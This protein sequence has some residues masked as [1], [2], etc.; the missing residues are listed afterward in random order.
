MLVLH[1]RDAAADFLALHGLD[2]G[3]HLVLAEIAARQL[4]HRLRGQVEGRQRDEVVE[5]ARAGRDVGLEAGQTRVRLKPDLG[6][7]VVGLHQLV[8]FRVV[9]GLDLALGDPLV[10]HLLA[11]VQGPVE[12][13]RVVVGQLGVRHFLADLGHHAGDLIHVRGVGLDPQQVRA[14]IAQAGNAVLDHAGAAGAFLEREQAVRQ[15]DR[16]HE[17][18][19]LEDRELA[20]L[21]R[22]GFGDLLGL[23]PLDVLAGQ[24]AR[25]LADRHLLGQAGAKAVGSCDDHALVDAQLLEGEAAGAQL[26]DEVLARDGD[27]AVLVAALLGVRHLVLDLQAAGAGLDEF[28]GQQVGRVFVAEARVD[29]GDDRDDMGFKVVDLIDDL[30]AL[31]VRARGFQRAEQVVHG[32]LVGLAQRGVDFLDQVGDGGL[33]MHRLV[34]QVAPAIAK[35]RDHPARQVDI[36]ALG[37]A[38]HPLDGLDHLLGVKARPAAER[39]GELRRVGVIGRHVGAHHHRHLAGDVQ[40]GVPGVLQPQLH[41]VVD[42]HPAGGLAGGVAGRDLGV[43]VA[44]GLAGHR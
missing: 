33:F 39:L 26:F 24:I 6:R 43:Q 13:G 25:A 4:V 27:L 20:F 19:A 28:L 11:K 44:E 2:V 16:F 40:V 17:L 42:R 38:A 8:A 23:E 35:P 1:R 34:G 10:A 12:A 41:D 21:D 5:H 36:G 32:D 7:V 15:A 9:G 31:G 14:A 30:A 22:V 18:A 37:G 29:V 3:Q